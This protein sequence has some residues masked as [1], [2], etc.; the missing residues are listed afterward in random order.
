[1]GDLRDAAAC[2][3]A[4]RGVGVVFHLA[5][6]VSVPMSLARPEETLEVNV[7]G[8]ATLL[9]A[10]RDA[11]VERV[12]YASSAS[13]YGDAER[14]P[15]REGE[16]GL[17]QSPYALSK[18]R[19]EE[20]AS[21]FQARLALPTVGLRY[22]NVYGPRQDPEGP[23]AA[24]VPRFASAL[25]AGGAPEVHGDGGQSRDFVF[26]GDVVAANLRAAAA[27]TPATGR[28]YNVASGR[29]TTLLEL[30]AAL[31]RL[32]GTAREPA[33]AAAREGD[34]RRS[35]GDPSLAARALGFTCSVDLEEG[36]ARSLDWYR[37]VARATTAAGH[38]SP[39]IAR[40]SSG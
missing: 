28:A 7:A 20:L 31:Q 24:V 29:S 33:F 36:L 17:P 11:G 26:V 2:R 14:L 18:R 32:L 37:R 30:L 40:S 15:S 21:H 1:V 38:P 3:A 19:V 9:H 23:Y 12:V 16:E 27:V 34:L 10:A 13:V 6:R 8:T 5:A 35:V 25:L 39:A 4:C 22:F